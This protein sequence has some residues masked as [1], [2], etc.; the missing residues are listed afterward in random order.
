M[1]VADGGLESYGY[2]ALEI[3]QCLAERRRGYET[4]VAAVRCLTGDAFWA[5]VES[6]GEWSAALQQTALDA[7]G[8]APGTLRAFWDAGAVSRD[9][10]DRRAAQPQPWLQHTGAPRGRPAPRPTRG[11]GGGSGPPSGAVPR[12]AARHRA[13][14][15]RVRRAPGRRPAPA[16][17]GTP[18][19]TWFLQQR[20]AHQLWHFDAQVDH[21]ERLVETGRAPYPLE[22]TLL[23]TGLIDAVMTSRHEGGRRLETPHLAIRYAPPEATVRLSAF[24][25]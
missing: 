12:R 18:W 11:R 14:A 22:R 25:Y 6:G 10:Q 24:A 8:H 7:I 20:A 21:I 3:A 2:H 1:V 23:T 17:T 13:H 4:G 16:W 15:R 5:A 9:E 19:A